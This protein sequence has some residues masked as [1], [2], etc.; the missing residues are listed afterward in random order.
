MVLRPDTTDL[1]DIAVEAWSKFLIMT[2]A[3]FE[4]LIRFPFYFKFNETFLYAL[5]DEVVELEVDLF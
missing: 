5:L 3:V 1:V 4:L 2:H